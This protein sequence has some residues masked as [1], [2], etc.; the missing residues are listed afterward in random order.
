MDSLKIYRDKEACLALVAAIKRISTK[1]VI[2]MEVCGGH[3]VALHRYGIPSLLPST[4]KLVSGPGCPVCVTH[5]GFIDQAIALSHLD[6]T[7]I[8]TFGDLIR[9]PGSHSTLEQAKAAGRKIQIVCSPL[10]ALDLAQQHPDKQI[11]FLG[12]GFET[13]APTSAAA[14]LEAREKGI[15]NFSILSAHKIMPPAMAALITQGVPIDGYI[16]PGHVSVV[17]GASIYTEIAKKFKKACVISGFEPLDILQ[18]IYMLIKQIENKAPTVE[19][20]Y[21]RAVRPEGNI[22]A[23]ELMLQV[24]QTAD[25]W[26]R[27]LGN[28]PNSGLKIRNEF[29]PFDAEKRFPLEIPEP[30]EPSGCRCGDI[31]KGMAKPSQCPLYKRVCTPQNPVGACMVSSEGTCAAF[32]QYTHDD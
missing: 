16:C 24:F 14:I 11:V 29:S 19:I 15:K 21:A 12:I 27:G 1:P 6:K 2:L 17:T 20:E 32:F 5:I 18:S 22:K 30:R 9:V 7:M 4:I 23:R 28:I 25:A 13:T 8:A 10:D 3:T 26:W 31:L